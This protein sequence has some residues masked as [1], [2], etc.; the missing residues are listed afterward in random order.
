MDGR[1]TRDELVKAMSAWADALDQREPMLPWMPLVLLERAVELEGDEAAL[2]VADH[3][4]QVEE[5]DLTV[6]ALRL[7]GEHD[8]RP[9]AVEVAVTVL[10]GESHL[11]FVSPV[12]V[13]RVVELDLLGLLRSKEPLPFSG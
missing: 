5:L 11:P 4:A 12:V 9:W 3:L 10:V 13:M 2:R 7:L 1:A 6:K 8:L